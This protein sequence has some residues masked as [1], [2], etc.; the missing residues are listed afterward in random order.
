M[1]SLQPRFGR[2]DLATVIHASLCASVHS[3]T[4]ATTT[5]VSSILPPLPIGVSRSPP[6]P[7][8]GTDF[9]WDSCT[10]RWARCARIAGSVTWCLPDFGGRQ[11]L[12]MST[13]SSRNRLSKTPSLPMTTRSPSYAETQWTALPRSM[14]SIVISSSKS[15]SMRSSTLA[16]CR[17]VC[18]CPSMRCISV[19]NATCIGLDLDGKRR[20]SKSSQSPTVMT[21]T[22]G[23]SFPWILVLL[24]RT[25][26]MH[27]VEPRASVPSNALLNSCIGPR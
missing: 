21:A 6:A 24:S 27:V 12:Q 10:R 8:L 16:S 4:S 2:R 18:T 15:G 19:W 22:I 26:R 1:K 20:S 17:G 3:M 25:A 11:A 7:G 13:T 23:C 14:T 5:D 9:A